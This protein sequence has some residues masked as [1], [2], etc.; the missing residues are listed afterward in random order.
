M[1]VGVYAHELPNTDYNIEVAVG[2]A[3]E[4]SAEICILGIESLLSTEADNEEDI[5]DGD[6]DE[7]DVDE[8]EPCGDNG[9]SFFHVSWNS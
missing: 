3:P 1:P 2:D 6:V 7:G 5:D 8:G 9:G 4:V